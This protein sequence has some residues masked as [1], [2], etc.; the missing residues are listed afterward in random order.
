M[1]INTERYPFDNLYFRK[2]ISAAIDKEAVLTVATNGQGAVSMSPNPEV[3]SG[4]TRENTIPYDPEQAQKYLDESGV[5]VSGLTFTCITYTDTTRRTAEVIQ[6][7]LAQ[8]GVTMEIES[9]DFA[10]Y[11]SNML[12]G[13]FD[14]VIGG[15]TASDM[16]TYMKALWHSSSIGASNV[17]RV[18]DPEI[19]SLIDLALT[20]LDPAEKT[21]T[22]EKVC[23]RVNDQCLM[24]SLY[25]SSVVRAYNSQLHGADVSA[26]GQMLYQD[27][28]WAE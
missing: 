12:E 3:F 8:I 24:I 25:T 17:P 21:A 15:Y 10:A 26:S 9:M 5:D 6:G 11:L 7:Y 27:L 14:A 20:Q 13:N 19:D 1:G 4:A 2:A 23:A 16:L 18:S 22:L 28:S